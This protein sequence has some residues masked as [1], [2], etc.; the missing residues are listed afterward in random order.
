MT[1][2]EQQTANVIPSPVWWR[3]AKALVQVSSGLLIHP[4]Q[5]MQSLYADPWLVWLALLPTG[6]LAAITI[7]WRLLLIP[8]L[9]SLF[10]CSAVPWQLCLFI[11]FVGNV[12]TFFCVYWQIILLYLLFRFAAAFKHE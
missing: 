8:L 7:V 5:T 11:P 10:A 12:L 9:S 1:E 6:V 2:N 3:I 4:Y